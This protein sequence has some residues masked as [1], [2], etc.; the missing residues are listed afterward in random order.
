MQHPDN[1][2]R[3]TR[4]LKAV[5]YS[6]YS[7]LFSFAESYRFNTV[8][9]TS[10]LYSV[11]GISHWICQFKYRLK[12]VMLLHFGLLILN[13]VI[14]RIDIVSACAHICFEN[15]S[16]KMQHLHIGTLNSVRIPS[17]IFSEIYDAVPPPSLS[18]SRKE[19]VLTLYFQVARDCTPRQ[20]YYQSVFVMLLLEVEGIQKEG[21]NVNDLK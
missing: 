6:E 1:P 18:V 9:K 20:L 19:L 4:R 16:R 7:H 8:G 13:G 5:R 2:V 11:L 21:R 12:E 3:V 17:F 14:R 15:N 10:C